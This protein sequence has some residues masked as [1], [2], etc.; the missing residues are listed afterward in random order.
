MKKE[1]NNDFIRQICIIS[2]K[3]GFFILYETLSKVIH[4]SYNRNENVSA[5]AC[6]NI[7]FNSAKNGNK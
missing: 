5:I 3:K 4:Y 2:K 6:V 7:I 1:L